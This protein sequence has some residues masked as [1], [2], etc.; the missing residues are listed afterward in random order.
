MNETLLDLGLNLGLNTVGLGLVAIAPKKLLTRA[1]IVHAWFLGVVTWACLGWPGYA[2]VGVY[3]V[4]GSAVT[5]LGAAR[6]EAAGIA[7]KRGGAR[8]P[9]NVWGSAAASAVCALAIGAIEVTLTT[10]LAQ[11]WL[12]LLTIGYVAGYSAKLADTL[13]LIHISEPTRPY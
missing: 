10:D 9:E 6:K 5:R 12:R 1:G 3:F 13:S 8:G 2:I 4:L 7:E 11:A